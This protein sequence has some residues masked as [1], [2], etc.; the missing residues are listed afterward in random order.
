M[1]IGVLVMAL[2]TMGAQTAKASDH[3]LSL[4]LSFGDKLPLEAT[5]APSVTWSISKEGALVQTGS[6]S[7]LLDYVFADPG[8]YEVLINEHLTADPN[9][10]D[11]GALPDEIDVAVSAIRMEFDFAHATFSAPITSGVVTGVILSIPVI[12]D[13]HD[14]SSFSF[15]PAEVPSAGVGSNLSAVPLESSLSLAPGT[16]LLR[17]QITGGVERPTYV[18]F[19]FVDVNGKV[20]PFSLN[21][22]L[23]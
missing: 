5:I 4:S 22:Q 14:G 15:T 2:W 19:D 8:T 16:H 12:V 21:Q 9:S 11:H 10:C 17:Y 3:S 23:H 20:Q 6:G 7:T 13:S 18:M 1:S